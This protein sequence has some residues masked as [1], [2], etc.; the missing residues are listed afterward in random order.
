MQ[1]QISINGT[2]G[3]WLSL[4]SGNTVTSTTFTFTAPAI[5]AA[6]TNITVA[7]R[8]ASATTITAISGV[9]SVN[10]VTSI[11]APLG[12]HLGTWLG[13]GGG[14][15]GSVI[16]HWNDVKSGLNRT[17]VVLA[18]V[19]MNSFDPNNGGPSPPASWGGDYSQWSSNGF[20]VDGSVS[21]LL[22]GHFTNGT[23]TDSDYAGVIAGTYDTYLT[24]AMNLWK[25]LGSFKKIYFRINW[26]FDANFLGWGVPSSSQVSNWVA[27]WKYWA[28]LLHT[29]G[30]N[31]GI[32][33]RMVWSPSTSYTI[34]GGTFGLPVINFFPTPDSNA[35]NNRYIDV[36]GCDNYM[37]SYSVNAPNLGQTGSTNWSMGTF[38][39]MCQAYNC[40]FGISETGDGSSF[41]NNASWTDGKMSGWATYLNTLA[42]LSPAVPIEYITIFDVSAGGASQ[43]TG[44]NLPNMLAAWRSCLGVSGNGSIP[45]I[46]TIPA[47]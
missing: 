10:A 9:Y 36:L 24:N 23:T 17:P 40:N 28:N 14:T 1:Y 5:A 47:T 4:P 38:V 46:M 37:N 13:G 7:V 3:S 34:G 15:E 45:T 19:L 32:A 6:S 12:V 20:P 41:D 39:A 2:A 44:G 42:T 16:G 30:N 29:W 33:V 11:E 18:A 22:H 43:F 21:P 31:N 8:D 27:A 35:V 25:G 26:E